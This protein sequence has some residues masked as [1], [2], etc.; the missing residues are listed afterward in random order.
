M[1][2]KKS[3]FQINLQV[4]F[5]ALYFLFTSLNPLHA[6]QYLRDPDIE[7]AL[8]R[9]AQPILE[10]AGLSASRVKIILI[11]DSKPN[12]FVVDNNHIFIHSGLVMRLK[13]A[14][15]L[16]A[17]IAHEAAHISSGHITRRHLNFQKANR[18]RALG[19]LLSG[20]VLAGTGN[21]EAATGIALGSAGTSKRLFFAH[22]RSEEAS[23]DE[24]A[25][26]YLKRAGIDPESMN[27]VLNL[28]RGQE[29]LSAK[30]QDPYART[31]PL[32][33]DRL[34]A[35]KGFVAG[36]T[37]TYKENQ[38]AQYWYERAKQKLSAFIVSPKTTLK[39]VN[40]IAYADIAL[41]AKAVALHRQPN[42]NEAI[43]AIAQLTKAHPS[44]P[45]YAE[46][47]GQIL[48]ENRKF[49]QAV[50]AYQRAAQLAPKNAQIQAGYGRA[51][52]ATQ[53]SSN[54]NK[55]I[56]ALENARARER[57]D[58]RVLRQLAAAYAKK[59]NRGMAALNGAE[60]HVLRGDLKAAK[61]LAT[62]A[63]KL[64]AHGS[65]GWN[66]L[67]DVLVAIKLATK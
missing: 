55:A 47:Q 59:G 37:K 45:Y 50:V 9:L 62:R 20:A 52:L 56:K 27:G 8:T 58:P 38:T 33:K 4:L 16:Q 5:M 2:Q 39:T 26:R 17:V 31:H 35:V 28:F 12:A 36:D 54:L 63:E 6:R 46:L 14:E 44:D 24:A 1:N 22:T 64:L 18:G 61:P 66:R 10:A 19:L 11:N 30:R 48:L 3:R 23:A 32:T 51:L 40:K 13:S 21:A 57:Y 67:Q 7:H 25:L 60:A 49:E 42:P 53:T 41:M 15:Q 65:V 34:R 29:F 43:R